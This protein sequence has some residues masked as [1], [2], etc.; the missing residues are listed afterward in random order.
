MCLASGAID[1]D[2]EHN[3]SSTRAEVK[4]THATVLD[5]PCT[6]LTLGDP[7]AGNQARCNLLLWTPPQQHQESEQEGVWHLFS[8]SATNSAAPMTPS[9][10]SAPNAVWG[11][12]R[13]PSAICKS[14]AA[15]ALR[16]LS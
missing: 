5:N 10:P 15:H 3:A 11:M 7:F 8:G 16:P 9:A 13:A 12:A 6:H 14:P 4:D 2:K 1:R